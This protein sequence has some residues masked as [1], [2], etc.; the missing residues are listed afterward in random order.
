MNK[1]KVRENAI[2]Q[3]PF[4]ALR[5]QLSILTCY[6]GWV[7]MPQA[8]WRPPQ[9]AWVADSYQLFVLSSCIFKGISWIIARFESHSGCIKHPIESVSDFDI[10]DCMMKGVSWISHSLWK[11]Y[12]QP[13]LSIGKSAFIFFIAFCREMVLFPIGMTPFFPEIESTWGSS[14]Q[15]IPRLHDDAV[16]HQDAEYLPIC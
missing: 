2:P 6:E 15:E 9:A 3:V 5:T 8:P 4:P 12:L 1:M 7:L 16:D 11:L 14:V 10:R 13:R